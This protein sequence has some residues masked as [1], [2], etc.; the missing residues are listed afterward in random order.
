MNADLS[1]CASFGDTSPWDRIDWSRCEREV[2]RLQARIVKATRKIRENG[3]PES[4]EKSGRHRE[5]S[6]EPSEHCDGAGT[7]PSRCGASTSR[8]PMG[9]FDRWESPR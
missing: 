3:L 8:K 6:I 5:P 9:N 7:N 4:M 2:R 1:A